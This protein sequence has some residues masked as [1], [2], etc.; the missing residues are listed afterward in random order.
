M[1]HR[2][3]TGLPAVTPS[4]LTDAPDFLRLIVE[5]VVQAVRA[6]E[7][8]AHLHAEPD[9]RSPARRGYRNGF[10]SRQR[11]T[12]VGTLMVQ[13]PQDRDG[14]YSP[15]LLARY[16]RTEQALALALMELHVEGISTRKVRD[17]TEALCGTRCSKCLVSAR[18]EP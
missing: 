13:V 15:Q 1:A 4:M 16:Q 12:R 9:E 17:I 5:R 3:R 7:M 8:T 11:H 10:T 18:V 14:T 6:A 2:P